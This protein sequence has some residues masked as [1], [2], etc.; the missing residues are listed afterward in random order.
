MTSD[1]AVPRSNLTSVSSSFFR[2]FFFLQS[3]DSEKFQSLSHVGQ[4]PPHMRASEVYSYHLGVSMRI[5][6]LRGYYRELQT[7][8]QSMCSNGRLAIETYIKSLMC[9]RLREMI[10]TTGENR[11]IAK[12]CVLTL[13]VENRTEPEMGSRSELLLF[14]SE[15]K[16][17][18]THTRKWRHASIE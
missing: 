2:H 6:N 7:S 4:W 8:G 1:P 10:N 11:Q 14:I 12:C 15:R 9:V 17:G 3:E 5:T 18:Y 16:V 13:L